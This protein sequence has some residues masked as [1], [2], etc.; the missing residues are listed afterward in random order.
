MTEQSSWPLK[1]SALC[2]TL[3]AYGVRAGP[4][5][6]RAWPGCVTH[7][8]FQHLT[9]FGRM[10]QSPSHPNQGGSWGEMDREAIMDDFVEAVRQLDISERQVADQRRI[11]DLLTEFGRDATTAREQLMALERAHAHNMDRRD[12][13]RALLEE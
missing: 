13:L 9:Q 5:F 2:G 1:S 8:K 4:A 11:V 3:A 12:Q 7:R 10:T 6:A